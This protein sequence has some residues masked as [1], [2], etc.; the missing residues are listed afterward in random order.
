[1][2]SV[3]DVQDD[4]VVPDEE[5]AKAGADPI[6]VGGVD[7][8]SDGHHRREVPAVGADLGATAVK[9]AVSLSSRNCHRHQGPHFWRRPTRRR[10]KLTPTV[11]PKPKG[12]GSRL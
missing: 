2:L 9:T 3:A 7:F 5:T 12:T 11:P 1:M 10:P 8:T 4:G 6:D